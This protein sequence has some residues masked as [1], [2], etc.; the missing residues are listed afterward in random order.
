[1]AVDPVILLNKEELAAVLEVVVVE[2][3][4]EL[5]LLGLL[6]WLDAL[7]ALLSIFA[8]PV[9]FSRA[10]DD[11]AG[12]WRAGETA[13]QRGSRRCS[14]YPMH[15]LHSVQRRRVGSAALV[16]SAKGTAAT[17]SKT[18]ACRCSHHE[19]RVHA[20]YCHLQRARY[21]SLSVS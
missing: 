3:L 17:L 6:L 5:V 9:G 1:M 8:S 13:Y 11:A 21:S 12:S 15:L 4:S 10:S 7:R 2:L 20:R 18:A 16:D 14:E 19:L